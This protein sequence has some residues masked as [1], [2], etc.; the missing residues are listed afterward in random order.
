MSI[1][2]NKDTK[3]IIQGITGK[4]G[5]KI[6]R[7]MVDYGT[8]VLAGV[9]PGKGGSVVC[10]V[11]VYD[12]MA[13]ALE[14]HPE[15][16]TSLISVPREQA[17]A[18]AFEAISSGKISLVNILTE[19]IPSLDSAYIVDY[20]RDY[21]VRVV[22]P[23]SVGIISPADKVKTGAIGGND[24]GVFYPGNIA[25]FS[26]SGG[27]CM[28]IALEIFN[29]LGY[30]VS[31]VVGL[32]G[33]KIIGTTFKD[34]LELIR[35]DSETRLVILN[36]EVG[37]NFE[38]EAAE[39]IRKTG[40][41]KRVVARMSGVGGEALFARGS[42]MG[43]AGAIIGDGAV[44]SYDSKVSALE[45][46]GVSVARSSED[47][48]TL[49]EREMPRRGP[50]FEKAIA[51]DVELVSIS[52]PKLE[53]L[54]KQVRAVQVKT[55]LTQLQ[56]GVPYFRGYALPDLMTS[57]SIPEVVLMALREADPR[58]EELN[59]FHKEWES[60]NER[61]TLSQAA[62][63][64]ARSAYEAGNS[65]NAACAAGLLAVPEITLPD[66][67]EREGTVAL[68][69]GTSNVHEIKALTHFREVMGITAHILGHDFPLLSKEGLGEVPGTPVSS[70]EE[71]FFQVLAGR[72]PTEAE[73]QVA[74]AI[75]IACID[76][77]PATPS[78]LAAL[79]VYSGGNSLKTALAAGISAMGDTHAGAG[80]GAS[81]VLRSFMSRYETSGGDYR[82]DGVEITS[83]E[84]LAQYIVDK[85]AGKF[86]DAKKKIPGYGHRYYSLYGEDARAVAL[87]D[88]A[89]K[90]GVA[91]AHTQLAVAIE[92]LLKEK[93]AGL[94]LN[95]DGAI[96]ALLADMK[97][98]SNAGKSTFIIPRTIGLLGELLEQS[99]GSFFR[100]A[101]ESVVY[102]G[103]EPGR[104]YEP[105]H[106]A[107]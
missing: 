43:H 73:A 52:K 31:I 27:M 10:G 71:D 86:G 96:G 42:R 1:L 40:F 105:V 85:C 28:S 70:I 21:N 50:D 107:G 12:T 14:K 102:T 47:L 20:A 7:E 82:V 92:H 77:T 88:I 9:T 93:T 84:A 106:A 64:A 44:G 72:T 90:T 29:K 104:D 94:C 18:A 87:L 81:Q 51:G 67:G 39:Y 62:L 76:H 45:A 41:P 35:D 61:V 68:P 19:G 98:S 22:G 23:A 11:P 83:I 75:F 55:S 36:G 78:S 99:A 79:T 66:P 48:I 33:D 2:V 15:A 95:V 3:V 103:P 59:E 97:I 25:I 34:L 8:T 56:N 16:N 54:K 26:K 57:A 69:Y 100:L 30:G 89:R 17:K 6:A 53:S 91:G 37:G 5:I 101:N 32:G 80:E 65:L 63:D 4:Q 38:E 58:P 24:P 49:V 46:A 74:R 13:D 60:V